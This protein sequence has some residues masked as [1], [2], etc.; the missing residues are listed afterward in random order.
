[1]ADKKLE[2]KCPIISFTKNEFIRGTN[3]VPIEKYRQSKCPIDSI[4][5]GQ[6][7]QDAY[8]EILNSNYY[9][10][11]KEKENIQIV[12]PN[13]AITLFD[14]F[15]NPE[16][17]PAPSDG[18]IKTMLLKNLDRSDN[19][20][21]SMDNRIILNT[22]Y[23]YPEIF[24][25]TDNQNP[26]QR[27]IEESTLCT[28]REAIAGGL[29][30]DA[31]DKAVVCRWWPAIID[32][33]NCLA[34]PLKITFTYEICYG[35]TGTTEKLSYNKKNNEE[36]IINKTL[37]RTDSAGTY[38]LR[39]IHTEH[40]TLD[41]VLLF[42]YDW[43]LSMNFNGRQIKT[44]YYDI[45]M[46][47][48]YPKFTT[49]ETQAIFAT[50]WRDVF[51]QNTDLGDKF[52]I[53]RGLAN[54]KM[55]DK[56]K[57]NRDLTRRLNSIDAKLQSDLRNTTNT[58]RIQEL[59]EAA[60]S[61][62]RALISNAARSIIDDAHTEEWKKFRK[63]IVMRSTLEAQ[64]LIDNFNSYGSYQSTSRIRDFNLQADEKCADCINYYR[65]NVEVEYVSS[66]YMS[67]INRLGNKDPMLTA[68]GLDRGGDTNNFGDD[69]D[70]RALSWHK[71]NLSIN[72]RNTTRLNFP[73]TLDI[74]NK[75]QIFSLNT[76]LQP[77]E[78]SYVPQTIEDLSDEDVRS[79]W[80]DG[81][82][83]G[84]KNI[85]IIGCG[86]IPPYDSIENDLSGVTPGY[87]SRTTVSPY[88]QL[89]YIA[90]LSK[91]LVFHNDS[92]LA[93]ACDR[94]GI[95]FIKF[96]SNDPQDLFSPEQL[97][98]FR[99]VKDNRRVSVGRRFDPKDEPAATKLLDRI[100][101]Q[102]VKFNKYN[103]WYKVQHGAINEN[104]QPKFPMIKP[105]EIVSQR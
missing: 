71:S 7:P 72:Y 42:D 59:T 5:P 77:L 81:G 4:R 74:D 6:P 100:K 2:P 103:S 50:L 102:I 98:F 54:D 18:Q 61:Q 80:T 32:G 57:L 105:E 83:V 90:E 34:Y 65:N 41:Y 35:L 10:I 11:P 79:A 22:A 39:T 92:D 21:I 31:S 44:P 76:K 82:R 63:S 37:K 30:F 70:P 69:R 58:Q 29:M 73:L 36:I 95:L 45:A 28:P 99:K 20:L 67:S 89:G 60:E 8:K 48:K 16:D 78:P 46:N 33:K 88:S 66:F 1:M 12:A 49:K 52:S 91:Y 87:L 93:F 27:I 25:S 47:N 97:I 24:D 68:H 14:C 104:N 17:I 38:K 84:G 3:P 55:M 86:Y 94:A 9:I 19:I 56:L 64:K 96:Y 26:P 40:L 15:T 13:E 51:S 53:K 43:S 101:N 85:N 62:K 23:D 75:T